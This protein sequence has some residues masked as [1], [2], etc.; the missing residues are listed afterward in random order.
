MPGNEGVGSS[1]GPMAL[2]LRDVELFMSS[3][4]NEQTR[5]WE[6]EHSLLR[7]PWRKVDSLLSSVQP[8]RK[9]TLGVMLQDGVVTPTAPVRRALTH[10]VDKLKAFSQ[11]SSAAVEIELKL[12]EP[13]DL[14]NRAWNII[15]SL[16]FMDSGKLIRTLAKA[17]GE[18]LLPLTQFIMAEPFVRSDTVGQAEMTTSEVWSQVRT[19]EAF[20]KE[21]LAQW[22]QLG[23]DCLLCPVMSSVAPRPGKIR[24]WGYTSVFNLV[25]YPGV[26]FPSGMFADSKLDEA[27]EAQEAAKADPTD[28]L[29]YKQV[30]SDLSEFDHENRVEYSQHRAVFD[31][32]PIGL[33]LIGR[34]FH[35][36]VSLP[37]P[38][39]SF[40]C[41]AENRLLIIS[42]R[43]FGRSW[44]S[45]PSCWSTSANKPSSSVGSRTTY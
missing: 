44:S 31:G 32:A 35:D 37:C 8:R 40:A 1:I 28:V 42:S 30:G 12:W 29:V 13:K 6:K 43:W 21:F 24:Y 3:V 10:W 27:Y 5:P 15:R 25:D 22:N 19:R 36:E 7:L 34:R 33:Q 18:P 39:T 11:S 14:H 17:T 38:L 45:T 20:R 23:L 41:V 26:V 16:Y 4:V 2:S 9:I